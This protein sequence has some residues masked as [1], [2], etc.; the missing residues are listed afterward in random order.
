MRSFSSLNL[1]R[2]MNIRRSSFVTGFWMELQTAG[3]GEIQFQVEESE[4]I[5]SQTAVVYAFGYDLSVLSRMKTHLPS[6]A[7]LC[8]SSRRMA[9]TSIPRTEELAS[10]TAFW[11]RLQVIH[12]NRKTSNPQLTQHHPPAR[13]ST[14]NP[15]SSDLQASTSGCRR[16]VHRRTDPASAGRSNRQARAKAVGRTSVQAEPPPA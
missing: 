14:G 15:P 12:W 7:A 11:R 9:S 1:L 5:H 16:T 4:E 3:K 2:S 10:S 6:S 8:I 13:S